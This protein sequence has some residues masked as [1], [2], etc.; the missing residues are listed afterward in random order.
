LKKFEKV[1]SLESYNKYALEK[2]EEIKKK[3]DKK[4]A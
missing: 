1:V 2:I 3:M 4:A